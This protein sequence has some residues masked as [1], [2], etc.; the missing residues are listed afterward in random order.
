MISR[1]IL[2][3]SQ[4]RSFAMAATTTNSAGPVETSIRAKVTQ[5]VALHHSMGSSDSCFDF[6][7]AE[8][9]A[10][11]IR[12]DHHQRLVAAPT[13]CCDEGEWRGK[14]RDTCV[15][16]LRYLAKS[17]RISR[18]FFAGGFWRV[19]GKG[20]SNAQN[21]LHLCSHVYFPRTLCSDIGWSILHCPRSCLKVCMPCQ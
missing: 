7:I 18:F 16:N 19:Q 6:C 5:S 3:F 12:V 11:T 14:R 10:W 2:Y 15:V 4:R 20:T 21:T 8:C 9:T 1:S 17:L 13:S